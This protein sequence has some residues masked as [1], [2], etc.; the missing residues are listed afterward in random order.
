MGM[1]LRTFA[2]YQAAHLP[3]QASFAA[4][5]KKQSLNLVFFPQKIINI[6]INVF[7]RVNIGCC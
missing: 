3:H 5:G 7:T 1:Y 2:F 6:H 4:Q